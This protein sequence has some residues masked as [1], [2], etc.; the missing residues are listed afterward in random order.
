ML[1]IDAPGV[2][3]RKARV[4]REGFTEDA[5]LKRVLGRGRLQPSE[6]AL[7]RPMGNRRAAHAHGQQALGDLVPQEA[8]SFFFN[9]R[10]NIIN[11]NHKTMTVNTYRTH[12]SCQTLN[13]SI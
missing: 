11:S 12:N 10:S 13:L 1:T 9:W 4:V 3:K 7:G 6:A 5:E 2:Q 8:T